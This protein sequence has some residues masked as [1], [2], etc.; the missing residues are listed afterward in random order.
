MIMTNYAFVMN[1][2]LYVKHN[3]PKVQQQD[4]NLASSEGACC[5]MHSGK[6]TGC[7]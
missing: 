7:L 3:H 5:I 1:L 4:Y 2:F 6:A